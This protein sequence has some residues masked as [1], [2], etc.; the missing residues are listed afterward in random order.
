[1]KVI[2]ALKHAGL[3]EVRH[4]HCHAYFE[5]FQSFQQCI[6]RNKEAFPGVRIPISIGVEGNRN[7]EP[8]TLTVRNQHVISG[9]RTDGKNGILV[10]GPLYLEIEAEHSHG[11]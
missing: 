3:R 2:D 7:S 4:T 5:P 11:P 1:M 9:D 8:C 6:E 10:V